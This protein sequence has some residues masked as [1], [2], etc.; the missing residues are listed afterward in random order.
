MCLRASAKT[1]IKPPLFLEEQGACQLLTPG[2]EVL[3]R[4][5]SHCCSLI[6]PALSI[7]TGGYWGRMEPG[8]VSGSPSQGPRKQRCSCSGAAW[9]APGVRHHSC[10]WASAAEPGIL[11]EKQDAGN[12]KFLTLRTQPRGINLFKEQNPFQAPFMKPE[13]EKGF[14]ED[15]LL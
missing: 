1:A 13:V 4:P 12:W 9:D 15:L 3:S 11:W 10:P 2:G 7:L 6:A 14:K 8:G 5:L